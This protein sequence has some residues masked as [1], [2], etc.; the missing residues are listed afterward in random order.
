MTTTKQTPRE[1]LQAVLRASGWKQDETA[2]R[3]GFT[4]RMEPDPNV[5]VIDAAHGGQWHL[6]LDYRDRNGW[7]VCYDDLLRGGELTYIAPDAELVQ[8]ADSDYPAYLEES[9]PFGQEKTGYRAQSLSL[10][11]PTTDRTNV[12]L[13]E[14]TGLQE[15]GDVYHHKNGSAR[16]LRERA[17]VLAKNPDLSVWVAGVLQHEDEVRSHKAELAKR[18]E[19]QERARPLPVTV[20]QK[21]DHP[22]ETSEWG[23][24]TYK[25][26]RAAK[27]VDGA[28]GKSDFVKLLYDLSLA[29][30]NVWYAVDDDV[31]DKVTKG[32]LS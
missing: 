6:A 27:A 16:T 18:Q 29:V 22:W 20:S 12:W 31:L 4:R 19:A 28:D 3:Y 10:R 11:R 21:K 25:L 23:K 9:H 26:V 5:W 2:R 1:K 15:D 32:E 8:P 17:E 24:L 13:W 14:A 30:N 7:S